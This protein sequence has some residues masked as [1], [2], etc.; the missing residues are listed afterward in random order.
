MATVTVAHHPDLT[1]DRAMGV[2]KSHFF[3]KYDVYESST[4]GRLRRVVVKKN[5][6]TG[7]IV[8][9]KQE[10]DT[11]TFVFAAFIPSVLMR[12]LF[13]LIGLLIALLFLR[14]TWKAMEEEVR[15]FIENA[16]D[17]R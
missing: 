13:G 9:L 10:P 3:G 17:F 7:V 11:T 15:V 8:N 6:M 2:F 16:A 14:P 1:L 5:A 4:F 12:G